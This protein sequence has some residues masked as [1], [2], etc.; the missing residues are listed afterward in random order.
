MQ[1]HSA[2]TS[3]TARARSA[4]R[5]LALAAA[6]RELLAAVAPLLARLGEHLLDDADAREHGGGLDGHEDDLGVLAARHLFEALDVALSDEVLRGVAV[7]EHHARDLRDGLGLGL[8]VAQPRLRRALGGEYGGLLLALGA[9]D[10]GVLLALGA[11]DGGL[12]LAL[13]L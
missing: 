4:V 3:P 9:G 12:L 13:G 8:G 11:R 1:R 2:T 6:G 10:G 5:Q 7:V